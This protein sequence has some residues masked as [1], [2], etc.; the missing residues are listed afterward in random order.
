MEEML[1][2]A[3]AAFGGYN[4]GWSY[5][6]SDVGYEIKKY[7]PWQT[8][9]SLYYR[10]VEPKPASKYDTPRDSQKSKVYTEINILFIP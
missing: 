9:R 1:E 5:M 6:A 8:V 2:D 4:G 7:V 10:L 3:F